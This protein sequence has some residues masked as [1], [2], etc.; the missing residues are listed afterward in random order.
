MGKYSKLNHL[1][2]IWKG[3]HKIISE[4]VALLRSPLCQ[5]RSRIFEII[6]AVKKAPY[7]II[8]RLKETLSQQF[9]SSEPEKP[10]TTGQSI[11]EIV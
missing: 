7:V 2:N 6:D 3:V 8:T 4:L 9:T 11:L 5:S 10:I 1:A